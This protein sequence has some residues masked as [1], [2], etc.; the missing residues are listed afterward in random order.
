MASHSA[1]SNAPVKDMPKSSA[2][3]K[4]PLKDQIKGG[5]SKSVRG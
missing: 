5:G 3:K 2:I 1:H 4:S